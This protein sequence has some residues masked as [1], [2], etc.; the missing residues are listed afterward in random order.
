MITASSSHNAMVSLNCIP[1]MSIAQPKFHQQVLQVRALQA[2]LGGL[3]SDCTNSIICPVDCDRNRA[4]DLRVCLT[5][6][7]LY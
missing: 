4:M 5:Y 7:G 1:C 6:L 2:D 3:L